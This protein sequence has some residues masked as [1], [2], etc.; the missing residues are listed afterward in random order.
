MDKKRVKT[1]R[2]ISSNPRVMVQS[3]RLLVQEM[4][5]EG[6]AYPLHLGVT[7]AGPPSVAVVKSATTNS[8]NSNLA[9]IAE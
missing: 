2:T 4:N 5:R 6:M 3:V 7:A 9:N 1:P 8:D